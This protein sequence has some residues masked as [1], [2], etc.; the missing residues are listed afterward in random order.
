MGQE[1]GKN[2]DKTT[3]EITSKTVVFI[4]YITTIQGIRYQKIIT[5]GPNGPQYEHIHTYVMAG[6]E[7]G[8][9][10]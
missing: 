2:L 10:F 1:T 7:G 8:F 3:T 9:S 5:G 6:L 4:L